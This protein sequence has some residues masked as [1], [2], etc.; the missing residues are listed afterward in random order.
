MI[1]LWDEQQ[2][3]W[4]EIMEKLPIRKM[5]H[6]RESEHYEYLQ[7]YKQKVASILETV[8]GQQREEWNGLKKCWMPLPNMVL[9]F[10]DFRYVPLYNC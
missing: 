4:S 3:Y 5:P 10:P 6:S 2:K 8:A 9:T 1:P 7:Q